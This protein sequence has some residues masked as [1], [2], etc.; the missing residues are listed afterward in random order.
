MGQPLRSLS[1]V[2]AGTCS[3]RKK[4]SFVVLNPANLR[5]CLLLS[6]A[7]PVLTDTG[8]NGPS[9]LKRSE[10]FLGNMMAQGHGPN[11]WQNKV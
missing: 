10:T 7:E 1:T 11:Q 5:G 8:R 6:I 2:S 3:L 4:P 9:L